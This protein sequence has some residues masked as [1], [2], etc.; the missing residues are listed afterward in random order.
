ME[1]Q[2]EQ[3]FSKRQAY[4]RYDLTLIKEAYKT[5]RLDE[6]LAPSFLISGTNG[7]GTCSGFLA[8]LLASSNYK[9]GLFT[10]PHLCNFRERIQCSHREITDDL[11][12][13]ELSIIKNKLGISL[14]DKLSFFEVSTL[15][16][17]SVFSKYRTDVNVIEVGLGGALDATNI[18]NPIASIVVSLGYDH[19]AIL[20][21]TLKE[22]FAQKMGI[23]RRGRPLFLGIGRK[24]QIAFEIDS[25]LYQL[26]EKKGFILY[27]YGEHFLLDNKTV[28]IQS[29]SNNL[30][31]FN[32]VDSLYNFPPILRR[33]YS[34]AFSV[35][36]WFMT[37]EGRKA[38]LTESYQHR[39]Y[40]LCSFTPFS[41]MARF[42]MF[43]LRLSDGSTQKIILDV[44][45]NQ[46]SLK[47]A[48][49]SLGEKK[50]LSEFN[51]I[52]IFVS[53]LSDKPISSMIDYVQ[54]FSD[55]LVLFSCSNER[56]FSRDS[57]TKRHLKLPFYSS[58]DAVWKGSHGSSSTKAPWLICGSFFAIGEVLTFLQKVSKQFAH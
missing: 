43:N 46:E 14:Y 11:L 8:K 44:C 18:I 26:K 32:L 22:I 48:Y 57:L 9:V 17:F 47:E 15:L 24:D 20:G 34:L 5:L 37:R 19:Q 21:H 31:T 33:N 12:V 40:N 10:S 55:P 7:K 28:K 25:T 54:G 23:V 49:H 29:D 52:P 51:K 56:S 2:F 38:E 27:R 35:Y 6:K 1:D 4:I 3:I 41:L 30:K 13:E 58:F 39:D 50:I 53:I 36:H 16:G 42:Q 45:H